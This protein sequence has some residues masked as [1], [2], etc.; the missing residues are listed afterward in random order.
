MKDGTHDEDLMVWSTPEAEL[1]AG[2]PA[3][4]ARAPLAAW[5]AET[6]DLTSRFVGS[7]GIPGLISVAGGLPDPSL[8]PAETLADIAAR[9]IRET[10]NESLGYG[11]TAGLPALRDAI[12]AQ[13][14]A[15]GVNV[16]RDNVLITTSGTQGL[17]LVGKV[18]IE[19]GSRVGFDFPTYAGALDAFRPRRPEL[20]DLDLGANDL[21]QRLAGVS[22]AYLIPNFSNPTGHLVDLHTRQRLVDAGDTWI[23]E[24]DPY[25][26]LYYDH[27]P[28]PS[29]LELS[30]RARRGDGPYDGPVIQLG[31][32]SKQLAPG[33]RVGWVIAAPEM[34]A[35][36]TSAKQSADLCSNGLAQMMTL[37]AF[38]DGLI[39]DI[40]PR[41]LALYRERRDALCAALARHLSDRFDWEVPVG[42]MF[43]WVRSKDPALDIDR[44]L[45]IGT[46]EGVLVGPGTVFDPM[47]IAGPALRLN[48][49]GNPPEKLEEAMIRLRRAL[50]RMD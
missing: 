47:N 2:A 23:V 19:P 17:D 45:D 46:E 43:V 29:L 35:A 25:G 44:L 31:T 5:L 8:I 10:P 6:N 3:A 13:Y 40:R 7:A 16:T 34:I 33:L 14:R 49:T 24:D 11:P 1:G 27:A 12:A 9:V 22:M 36:L 4:A 28:L 38:R 41:A 42:G 21:A 20:V 26:A 15:R 18:L 50:E 39:E 48:F 32:L 30:S 37:A